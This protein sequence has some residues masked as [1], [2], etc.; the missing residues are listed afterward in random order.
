[1]YDRD[2]EYRCRLDKI[3]NGVGKPVQKSPAYALVHNWVQL[4]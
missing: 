1:M 3:E 4:G 2:D